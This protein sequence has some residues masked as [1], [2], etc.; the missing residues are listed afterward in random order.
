MCIII[1]KKSEVDIP[2]KKILAE[3]NNNNPDGIGIAYLKAGSCQVR[4]KKDFKNVKK[5]YNFLDANIDKKDLL[6]IHFRIATS[7]NVDKG[8]R[9]PFPISDNRGLMREL[10]VITN[11]AMSHNGILSQHSWMNTKFS[12]SQKFVMNVLSGIRN[13]LDNPAIQILIKDYIKNDKLAILNKDG[14]FTMFG[15]FIED[16]GLFYSNN[17]YK[18]AVFDWRSWTV[19]RDFNKRKFYH[20]DK[21]DAMIESDEDFKNKIPDS[22]CKGKFI[23]EAC[24]IK[25]HIIWYTLYG[26]LCSECRD[27]WEEIESEPFGN[28][29]LPDYSG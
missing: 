10:N 20:Y 15:D 3:C 8:N 28:D 4:I 23:C 9:H 24:G 6:M 27:D 5:L 26:K 13:E 2:S 29:D 1:V 14:K 22:D 12:D 18:K 16:G 25:T 17:S 19:G 21:N 7:G 11:M